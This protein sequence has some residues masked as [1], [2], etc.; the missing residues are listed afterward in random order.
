MQKKGSRYVA[1]GDTTQS[2]MNSIGTISRNTRTKQNDGLRRR[3]QKKGG[4]YQPK[5][6]TDVPPLEVRIE[7]TSDEDSDNES[8]AF[9]TLGTRKNTRMK[10]KGCLRI[11]SGRRAR[12]KGGRFKRMPPLVARGDNSSDDTSDN[13]SDDDITVPKEEHPAKPKASTKPDEEIVFRS[14]IPTED[15]IMSV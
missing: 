1:N 12:R 6:L 13:E 14:D 10:Q 4:R 2:D 3:A 15:Y 9:T 11:R 8:D 5:G 7:D